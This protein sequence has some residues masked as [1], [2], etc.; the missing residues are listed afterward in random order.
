M[1]VKQ[2]LDFFHNQK[3]GIHSNDDLFFDQNIGKSFNFIL[4][5]SIDSLLNNNIELI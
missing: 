4:R 2:K 3:T 5:K 1:F